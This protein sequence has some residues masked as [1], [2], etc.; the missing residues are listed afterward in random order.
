MKSLF[1]V[2]ITLFLLSSP[3]LAKDWQYD[4]NHSAVQFGVKHIFST[5]YGSFSDVKATI[6]FN[7]KNLDRSSFDFI[8]K[9]DSI[10][11]GNGKRDNH[12]RSKD[13]FDSGA[14]PVMRFTSSAI[15]HLNGN[16]Y[17]MKGTMTL[18]DTSKQMEIPFV[19]HG[20]APSPFDKSKMVAGFDT[21]FDIDR[22]EFGVGSGK[23]HKMGVVGREVQ[24]TIS[25]ETIG[26]R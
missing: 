23:F 14:F 15:T 11:T 10:D 22:L 24:V 6:H 25:V 18:K 26:S 19:F 21:K 17:S 13:F 16:A 3:A 5:V 1:R 4:A 9:V 2:L 12:L 7:P 20:T 8:V